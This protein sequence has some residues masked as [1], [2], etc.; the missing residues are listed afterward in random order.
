MFRQSGFDVRF[1]ITCNVGVHPRQTKKQK[2]DLD[3]IVSDGCTSLAIELKVPLAGRVPETMFDFY[4]DVAFVEAVVKAELADDGFCILMTNDP[5]F[6]S[7]KN[8]EDIYRPLRVRDEQLHGV[9]NKP[10][11]RCDQSVFVEGVYHPE[12]RALVNRL[13]LPDAKYVLLE[14]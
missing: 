9:F 11:G 12:W 14:I 7:G 5:L 1:E 2:R 3:L 8:N 6:W 13:L 10:T 4:A